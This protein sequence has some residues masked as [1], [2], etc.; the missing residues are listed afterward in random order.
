MC[1]V[2]LGGGVVVVMIAIMFCLRRCVRTTGVSSD[3]KSRTLSVIS[4]KGPSDRRYPS[5]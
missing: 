5:A 3:R 2:K 4:G 1:N